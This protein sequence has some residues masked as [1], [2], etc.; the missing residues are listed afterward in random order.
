MP[1]IKEHAVPIA[2]A[3]AVFILII[4]L[5]VA[6]SHRRNSSTSGTVKEEAAVMDDTGGEEEPV[7]PE[8]E[9]EEAWQPL[10]DE[11]EVALLAGDRIDPA[12]PVSGHV[13]TTVDDILR[14]RRR[15]QRHAHR[16]AATDLETSIS[17]DA[18]EDT[19]NIATILHMARQANL[20]RQTGHDAEHH[21]HQLQQALNRQ[22]APL[23]SGVTHRGPTDVAELKLTDKDFQIGRAHV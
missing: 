3:I 5:I 13:R 15:Q 7:A 23:V 14:S 18:A 12:P 22:A 9:E 10:E 21:I 19:S 4:S 6:S 1:S 17:D 20:A 16:A 11:E 2:I 8:G